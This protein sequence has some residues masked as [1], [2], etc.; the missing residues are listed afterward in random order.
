[1]QFLFLKSEHVRL[2]KCPKT[3]KKTINENLMGN[4][5]FQM[6][7][8]PFM[9]GLQKQIFTESGSSR[10]NFRVPKCYNFD[11]FFWVLFFGI[12]VFFVLLNNKLSKTGSSL[13]IILTVLNSANLNA[14]KLVVKY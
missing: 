6:F 13:V 5:G 1:M 4:N 9:L 7:T 2:R 14:S 3:L 10:H 8:Q 12:L 11:E